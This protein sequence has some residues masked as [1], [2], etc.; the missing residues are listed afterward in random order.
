MYL[1]EVIEVAI[2]VIFAWLL[3]SIATMQV[4]EIIARLLK[5]RARDLEMAI[6]NLLANPEMLKEFYEHPLIESLKEPLSAKK[7]QK[8]ATVK[9]KPTL[10]L[11]EKWRKMRTSNLPS[12]IPPETFSTVLFDIVTKAGT[13]SSPI[14]TTLKDLHAKVD[15]LSDPNAKAAIKA[16]LERASQLGQIAATTQVGEAVQKEIKKELKKQVQ[17]LHKKYEKQ[18]PQIDELRTRIEA[19]I[20][21]PMVDWQKLF[22]SDLFVNRIDT[23]IK[24]LLDNKNSSSLGTSLRSLLAGINEYASEADH[25]LAVGRTN[26][27]TWFDNSMDRL[28][29]WYRRW[30]QKIAF[31]IALVIAVAFNVDSIYIAQELWRNPAMREAT[32]AYIDDFVAKNTPS[33]T[34]TAGTEANT[35][36]NAATASQLNPSDI[37]LGEIRMQLETIAYP[38]GW[39]QLP[40]EKESAANKPTSSLFWLI[41][42]F[43]WLITAGAAM[44]GAPFWFDLLKKLVNVRSTG[45]NPTE[46]EQEKGTVAG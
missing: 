8:A 5:K 27:E 19:A 21:D 36:T 35:D 4:Q 43:G 14:Q 6:G 2:G 32:S 23:G 11:L 38:T 44:Q 18:I 3:I 29:G 40:Q 37:N 20:D 39:N 24:A 1:Q 12:Y 17:E 28:S 34:A 26:V 45:I 16:G 25:A 13:E 46:K 10:N 15:A 41:K 31:I 9:D 33:E 30:A 42:L 7:A 22:T